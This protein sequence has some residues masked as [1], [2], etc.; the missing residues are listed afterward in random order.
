VRVRRVVLCLATLAAVFTGCGS[1]PPAK[2]ATPGPASVA[3]V[4]AVTASTPTLAPTPVPSATPT[5]AAQ[6]YSV[7]SGDTLG[8]IAARFKVSVSALQQVNGLSG[9]A[10]HIGQSLQIPAPVAPPATFAVPGTPPA[11]TSPAKLIAIGATGRTDSNAVAL[12]FDAGA[13]AGYTELILDTLRR[14]AILAT[15]GMT[16]QW[17]QQNPDL[18]KRIGAAGHQF[19]N[20]TWNHRSWT[21]LSAKPAVTSQQD[22]WSEIDQTEAIVYQLTGKSTLPYFRAPFG[23]QDPSV[24]RDIGLRGYRYDV[25]W[26]IDTRGWAGATPGQITA[27]CA[28][29]EAGAIIVMHVGAQ[30][31]DGPAL[32]S[33]IDAIRQNGLGFATVAELLG[34]N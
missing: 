22:R 32:Q 14:N 28:R 9:D 1:R 11:D 6:Q 2:R 31:Q 29:A 4:I 7:Q 3:A 17:A 18:V 30:S 10:L 24:Q 5:P 19:M 21:G 15:F 8:L 16:G 27:A 33:C 12:T 23:D 26:T 13:D 20:H 25:L 34:G